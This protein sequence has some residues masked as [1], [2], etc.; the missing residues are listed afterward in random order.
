M[1]RGDILL[2]ECKLVTQPPHYMYLVVLPDLRS[3][4]FSLEIEL[5]IRRGWARASDLH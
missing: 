2:V 4:E 5:G 1:S 3:L